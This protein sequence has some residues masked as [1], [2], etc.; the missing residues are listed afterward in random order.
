MFHYNLFFQRSISLEDTIC[1]RNSSVAA[2]SLFMK[3]RYPSY[4]LCD[5][6]FTTMSIGVVGMS[7]D[8]LYVIE[9]HFILSMM[10]ETSSRVLAK[11][12]L[13]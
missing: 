4:D 10:I 12:L 3:E 1:G 2:N 8:S 7:K 9:V 5:K 11:T 13:S 6:P